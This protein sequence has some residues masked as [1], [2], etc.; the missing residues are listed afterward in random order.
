MRKEPSGEEK[1]TSI[2]GIVKLQNKT[3]T[4]HLPV[5]L[6]VTL[7]LLHSKP[8]LSLSLAQ[9]EGPSCHASSLNLRKDVFKAA[10]GPVDQYLAK[11]S[12]VWS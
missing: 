8:L 2:S 7:T 12:L 4:E 11:L 1:G 5:F 9:L 10:S 3:Q 6:L